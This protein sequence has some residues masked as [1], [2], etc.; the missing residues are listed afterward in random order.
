MRHT[1]GL[2]LA[3][4]I[5]LAL[6][7]GGCDPAPTQSA[8]TASVPDTEAPVITLK[9]AN[10]AAVAQNGTYTDAGATVS[11]NVDDDVT[12]TVEGSVDTATPGTY[13]LTYTA[14][15]TAGNAATAERSVEV[16]ASATVSALAEATLMYDALPAVDTALKLYVENDAPNVMQGASGFDWQ[17]TLQPTGSDINLT[18]SANERSAAVTPPIA[19]IYEVQVTNDAGDMRTSRF[20]VNAAA[21][22]DALN[23]H[24]YDASEAIEAQAGLVSNQVWVASASLDR[25]GIEQAIT[26]IDG[27][28]IAGFDDAQ[29]V[30]IEFSTEDTN[31]TRSL[32]TLRYTPGVDSV[33][34]RLFE[35]AHTIKNG[36]STPDDGSA[37]DDGGD[38][39]H[40]EF[41]NIPDA[42]DVTTGST[43]F[44]VGLTDGQGEF[45]TQHEDL[46]GR[47]AEAIRTDDDAMLTHGTAAAGTI[48]AIT[49]NGQGVSGINQ[50]SRM[51]GTK[52]GYDG[53]SMLLNKD[54]VPLISNAWAIPGHITTDFDPTSVSGT[55]DRLVEAAA[56]TRPY[57]QAALQHP[58]RLLVWSAGNGIGNGIGLQ[59]DDAL[60]YGVNG[61]LHSPA[62]HYNDLGAPDK[63]DNVIT[64]AAT[65]ENAHL[66]YYSNYGLSVDIAAPTNF[67]ST[68]YDGED[69]YWESSDYDGNHFGSGY[70]G[71]SAAASIVSGVASLVYAVDP[72]LQAADVKA[73]LIDSATRYATDRYVVP[74]ASSAVATLSRK[75][76]IVDAAAAVNRALAIREG[77][78]TK[79]T[80][81]FP[82]PFAAQLAMAVGSASGYQTAEEITYSLTHIGTEQNT[83]LADNVTSEEANV[84]FDTQ[85]LS[86]AFHVSGTVDL[87][88]TRSDTVQTSTFEHNFSVAAVS[89]S[90]ED[91]VLLTAIAGASITLE[92]LE[93]VTFTNT[94]STA[95]A[96]GTLELYL[97][98][99]YYKLIATATDYQE[100]HTLIYLPESAQTLPV[101][102]Y[103]SST[104]ATSVGAI[105]GL[106]MDENGDLIEGASVRISGG[107]QTNGYFASA[108]TDAAGTFSL[109][110]VSNLD[111]SGSQITAFS[112]SAKADGY[113]ESIKEDLVILNGS[114]TTHV[115]TLRLKNYTD[116][117]VYVNGF[118][119]SVSD[120]N[121]TG[122][123]HEQNLSAYSLANTLVDDG[124]CSLP[125]DELTDRAYLPAPI[126]GTRVM[127]YG[128]ED[129]GSFIGTQASGDSALSGGTSTAANSGT[130]TSPT[131]SLVGLTRPY[132]TVMS[133]WE[134]ESVNPN[135][136][137]FDL[138][139]I[140]ISADG[141]SFE[142]VKRLNPFV[143][144]NDSDRTH[145]GFSSGGFN[146][147]P[148]WVEEEIDLSDYIGK[149]IQIRF[150]F[151]TVDGLYNGFRGW[152]LDDFA[153]VDR[154]YTS[155]TG[156]SLNPYDGL[157]DTF[158]STH[159]LPRQSVSTPA[160]R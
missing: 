62:I 93:G 70:T 83:T 148:V 153:I 90:V 57:R 157:S 126:S 1:T 37:F 53:L 84:T 116:D 58:D 26:A 8:G 33:A 149:K 28:S 44:F 98:P 127:W 158:V 69:A 43:E 92:P 61:R 128:Q 152:V 36:E 10:P 115:I 74:G 9:G 20:T 105:H 131:I 99:G 100:F 121:T 97:R 154:L 81:S 125:P 29:G 134:V 150:K 73:L 66:V 27:F 124:Y 41:I 118:D 137:G 143:D 12:V 68:K 89:V 160:T 145:K 155:T 76:P 72:T 111:S 16:V 82:D 85:G 117:P 123:W 71:T 139:D 96:N 75:I 65:A 130:L 48:G 54:A 151:D 88:D 32:E 147:M 23:L 60:F 159:K 87:R 45:L 49:D 30:L 11:D 35:G 25:V 94:V 101:K 135:A 22:F 55:N 146:R 15:D 129:T 3:A 39:W 108:E 122:M 112:L 31:Y 107:D 119:E 34:L 56:M 67:K 21:S 80:V 132:L 102:V 13:L 2:T 42:W 47:F 120:W 38:N 91:T 104:S 50:V 113:M 79:V 144:P 86:G 95:D 110:N 51:I 140:L 141:G 64:V 133:W 4:G 52:A 46:T 109:S 19:G 156:V 6:G 5:A 63:L 103:M 138:L 14:A 7:L 40:L 24:N 18:V 142:Q 78:I 136:S 114:A 17:L 59:I 106:V 77:N